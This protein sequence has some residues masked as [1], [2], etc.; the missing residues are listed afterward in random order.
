MAEPRLLVRGF[1]S[2]PV[3]YVRHA[4]A[5]RVCASVLLMANADFNLLFRRNSLAVSCTICTLL[6]LST[7]TSWPHSATILSS[8]LGKL[9]LTSIFR[10]PL[11]SFVVSGL[12]AHVAQVRIA[13]GSSCL[14]VAR[15]IKS[16]VLW[17]RGFI[18]RGTS[19]RTWFISFPPWEFD[20]S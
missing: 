13:L 17:Y 19:S 12:V 2:S 15:D 6:N 18:S 4:L 9:S 3:R 8:S 14:L 10:A 5:I 11:S 20:N 7:V 1:I 16:S